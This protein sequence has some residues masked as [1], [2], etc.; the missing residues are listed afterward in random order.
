[1]AA[2]KKPGK[3]EKAP[4]SRPTGS[5]MTGAE[6]KARVQGIIDAAEKK[7]GAGVVQVASKTNASYLLRRPTGITSLDIGMAGGWPA[8]APSVLVG[9]DG[10][11]KD[12]LLW[13]TATECQRLYGEDFCMAVY[14]TE[15]KP[16]KRYMK[17]FCGVQ[18]AFSEEELAELDQARFVAE[19]PPLTAA[20]L[21]HYRFQIG[22]FLPIYGCS[23][24]HG[25]DLIFEFLEQNTCQMVAVNSL[26]SLQTEAKEATEGFEDFAQQ[27]NEAML[28]SKVMPK[29]SMYLNRGSVDGLPN[30]TA[31]ILLNQ[32]RGNDEPKRTMPGRPSRPQDK[33]KAGSGSHALKHNKALE[34]FM[35]NG[36]EI[37]DE[38]DKSVVIGRKKTWEITK[39]KLG[40]HEG[41]K[42]EFNYF[43]GEGADIYGDLLNVTRELG[44]IPSG[45]WIAYADDA[46]FAFKCQG[47]ARAIKLLR[48]SPELVDHLRTRCF[49]ATELVYRHK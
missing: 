28:L 18:I 5:S 6:R 10:V 38:E 7:H 39:G 12:Y 20:E 8:S 15:F 13:R 24:D 36:S 11:G 3:K 49:Q 33:Y 40:T 9:P 29:V 23:A 21:D 25:F 43:H 1:M 44:I 27:R 19:Q 35:H 31:I 2:K 22:E 47:E 30:E 4:A 17:D 37:R 32:V 46:K 14:F 41:I 26:G 34:L 16:D 45:G 42:G 48:E